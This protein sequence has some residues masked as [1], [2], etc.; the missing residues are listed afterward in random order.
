MAAVAP[1][2]PSQR[3]HTNNSERHAAMA[4]MR[5]RRGGGGRDDRWADDDPPPRPPP[6]ASARPPREPASRPR[7]GAA[8][9]GSGH[10]GSTASSEAAPWAPAWDP[11]A[12][13][14][15]RTKTIASSSVVD[16][17][18]E[19]PPAPRCPAPPS[20]P[21]S[22]RP[23]SR[24][25]VVTA[26]T[27]STVPQAPVAAPPPSSSSR[28]TG[29]TAPSFEDDRRDRARVRGPAEARNARGGGEDDDI[30]PG[31]AGADFKT[32]QQMIARGIQNSEKT[33]LPEPEIRNDDAD[34]QRHRDEV[35]R[36]R[37]EEA[38][39]REQE[40]EAARQRRRRED[41]QRQR[42]QA[43]E[44]EKEFEAE[45]EERKKQ[46]AVQ[47]RCQ[48][49]MNAASSIQSRFRGRRSRA[50]KHLQSPF[51]KCELHSQPWADKHKQG[52]LDSLSR[53]D[54]PIDELS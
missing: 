4:R 17:L 22:G 32:L 31:A 6:S 8:L 38:K 10:S 7:S 54:T 15:P 29:R 49:E 19:P 46:L 43:E 30:P 52:A 26:A 53:R 1:P 3:R 42:R 28:C 9:G 33:E 41:E 48:R 11:H 27:G 12:T 51:V 24:G 16:D 18:D 34:L 50:G 2:W 13:P 39:A 21:P 35:R 44:L 47:A 37:E 45:V 5:E 36:R 25:R 14:S 40:R 20:G 23:S